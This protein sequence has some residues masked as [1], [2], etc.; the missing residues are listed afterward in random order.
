MFK[1]TLVTPEK[2]V[3]VDQEI[4]NV[5]VPAFSGTLDILPGHT[6]MIT[7][8]ETGILR[9]KL[10]GQDKGQ[11]AVV[12]W[13]YCEVHPQG[14][15]ILAEVLEMPEEVNLEER[16]QWITDA[17]KRLLSE[18]LDDENFELQRR[19]IAR[20]RAGFEILGEKH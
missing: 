4:D 11:K 14:V 3:V 10:K 12:S 15:D 13:G 5:I 2:K 8:L 9:W 19:E 1:L 7:T 17:E 6:P 18:N 16:K 20:A